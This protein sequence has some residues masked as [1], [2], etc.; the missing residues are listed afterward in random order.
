MTS[1]PQ[2]TARARRSRLI[3]LATLSA[4]ASRFVAIGTQLV[5][6]PLALHY[7][8]AEAFGLWMTVV[9]TMQLMAF[10]DLGLGLGLQNR[11]STAFG[12]DDHQEIHE[13]AYTGR[14]I[15]L[16]IGGVIV[17]AGLPLCWLVPWHEVFKVSDAGLRAS[18]PH[19]MSAALFAFA[20]GLPLS[21]GSRV[22][23]GLQLGWYTGVSTSA[24]SVLTLL[25]VAIAGF[26]ALPLPAFVAA[27]VVPP[28]LGHLGVGV[29]ARRQLEPPPPTWRPRY[30][31]DVARDVVKQGLLFLVPQVSASVM[32]AGPSLALAAMLGPAAVTPFS[33]GQRLAGV[34]LQFLQLPLGPL[35]PAYAEAKRRG[36]TAWITR[37]LKRSLAASAAGSLAAAGGLL[38]LGVPLIRW[39]TRQAAA[40]PPMLTLVGFA[41]WVLVVG[42]FAPAVI[43]LNGSGVLRGQALGGVVASTLMVLTLPLWVGS[44]G[45]PGA[46]FALVS[47]W[48]VGS[49]P[50]AVRDLWRSWPHITPSPSRS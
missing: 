47:S 43:Y 13:L 5:Q 28:L 50:F 33:V 9:G 12:A 49:L 40:V 42:S 18:L 38:W 26:T 14:R 11:V 19:A 2:L 21:V 16:G 24:G 10:A 32:N 17:A 34:A 6:V 15:L 41:L 27:S 8:S 36:D 39:W 1:E 35:W 23:T 30:R 37:T 29:M 25:M 20:L 45:A 46:I 4:S 7:L 3:V 48:L 44:L 22:A 31:R